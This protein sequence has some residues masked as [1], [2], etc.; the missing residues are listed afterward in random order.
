MYNRFKDI[1]EVQGMLP[2]KSPRFKPGIENYPLLNESGGAQVVIGSQYIG[3]R[4]AGCTDIIN[5]CAIHTCPDNGNGL[6]VPTLRVVGSP[7]GVAAS[8]DVE[9]NTTTL[10]I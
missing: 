5:P 8:A 4:Q 2:V 10:S 7:G 1:G 6:L 9:V 3:G